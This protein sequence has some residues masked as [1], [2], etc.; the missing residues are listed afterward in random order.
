LT[1]LNPDLSPALSE[2]EGE[3]GGLLVSTEFKIF[4]SVKYNLMFK[5]V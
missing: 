2:E 1:P 4:I 3:R 5:I